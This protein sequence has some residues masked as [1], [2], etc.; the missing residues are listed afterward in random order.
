MTLEVILRVIL[1]VPWKVKAPPS[2]RLE[3][4]SS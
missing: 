3:R 1:T 4:E 2:S